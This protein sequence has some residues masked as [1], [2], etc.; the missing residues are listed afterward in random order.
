MRM[1]LS[2]YTAQKF[3]PRRI[4]G[5]K[6]GRIQNFLIIAAF[7]ARHP[8]CRHNVPSQRPSNSRPHVTQALAYAELPQAGTK[9]DYYPQNPSKWVITGLCP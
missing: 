1:R 6:P 7:F 5:Q 2:P 4:I 3:L 9:L 8:E